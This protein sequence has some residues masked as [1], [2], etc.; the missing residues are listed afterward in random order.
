MIFFST[1]ANMNGGAP[2]NVGILAAEYL[3]RE[4]E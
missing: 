3:V 4:K 1:L 2:D